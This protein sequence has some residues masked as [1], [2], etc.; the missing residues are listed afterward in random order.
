[1]MLTAGFGRIDREPVLPLR[2]EDQWRQTRMKYWLD[3]DNQE[4]KVTELNLKRL[5][6]IW[7]E[8]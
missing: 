5:I 2:L 7:M 8:G 4:N 6:T 3:T 1:M